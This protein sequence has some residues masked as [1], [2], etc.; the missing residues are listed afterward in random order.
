MAT[1][2]SLLRGL[3][4]SCLITQVKGSSF[5]LSVSSISG[6]NNTCGGGLTF[7]KFERG[8]YGVGAKETLAMS[9]G[10]RI[11]FQ[12]ELVNEIVF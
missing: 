12:P 3:E 2:A 1:T 4:F 7:K 6:Y 9:Y 10:N 11:D 5:D 8:R